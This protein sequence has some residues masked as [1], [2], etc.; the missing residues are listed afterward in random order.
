MIDNIFKS[1]SSGDFLAHK[2]E[3]L[4]RAISK[5]RF[6]LLVEVGGSITLRKGF[7]KPNVNYY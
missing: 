5:K 2:N 1:Y 6:E 3:I 7:L 4:K